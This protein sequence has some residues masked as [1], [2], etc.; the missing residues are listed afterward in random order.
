MSKL[1]RVISKVFGLTG[2][3]SHFGKFGSQAAEDPV[4]TKDVALIQ[5]LSAWDTGWQDA[6][7]TAN[8]AP[9]LE[10]LNGAMYAISYQQNYMLQEGVPEWQTDAIYY[11]GSIV[12]KTGTFELYGSLTD[13][14]TGNAL[15]SRIDAVNWKYIGD[16][17][18]PS[19]KLIV[20]YAVTVAPGTATPMITIGNLDSDL[21]VS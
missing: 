19:E 4:Y 13:D 11:I 7:N 10:D 15:P 3:V 21:D 16:L 12:K 18:T 5:A 6:I 20:D 14:N 9:F 8:K 2:N 1:T 17:G